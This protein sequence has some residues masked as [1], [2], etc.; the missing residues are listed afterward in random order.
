MSLNQTELKDEK[1]NRR[2]GFFYSVTLHALLLLIAILPFLDPPADIDKNFAIVVEFEKPIVKSGSQSKSSAASSSSEESAKQ[3]EDEPRPQE[4]VEEVRKLNTT[5]LKPTTRPV[6]E[7]IKAPDLTS[8]KFPEPIETPQRINSIDWSV[9]MQFH[10]SKI[11]CYKFGIK[12]PYLLSIYHIWLFK[13]VSKF[14]QVYIKSCKT[15]ASQV[16]QGRDVPTMTFLCKEV[17][18]IPVVVWNHHLGVPSFCQTYSLNRLVDDAYL[19]NK[20]LSSLIT[21]CL[22]SMFQLLLT[23]SFLN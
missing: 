18:F 7:V 8:P 22:N 19:S 17:Y 12:N 5:E 6:E 14:M 20:L 10:A 23:F 2:K 9:S 15:D 21:C 1:K 13:D 16:L 3:G 11:I 4:A